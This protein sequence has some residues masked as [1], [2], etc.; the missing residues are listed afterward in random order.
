MRSIVVIFLLFVFAQYSTAQ[1]LLSGTYRNPK[2]EEFLIISD[3]SICF[4]LKTSEGLSSYCF[5][6]GTY[7][8]ADGLLSIIVDNTICYETSTILSNERADSLFSLRIVDV[9]DN[10]IKYGTVKIH[11]E[12][13]IDTKN[14]SSKIWKRW[15]K[16]RDKPG[17]GSI[18]DE[19]GFADDKVLMPFLNNVVCIEASTVGIEKMK[20]EFLIQ[21]GF[22]YVIKSRIPNG[23]FVCK[24][25]KM[26]IRVTI[27]PNGS[28]KYVTLFSEESGHEE[29]SVFLRISGNKEIGA[30]C[31]M[32]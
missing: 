27:M 28:L 24:S 13:N 25:K 19:N 31:F 26:E 12:N 17:T 3:D 23:V 18:T 8:Y 22:D 10:P 5:G 21:D 1:N 9:D 2:T 16:Y 14:C 7:N 29:S 15:T 11:Q 6:I 4:K 32:Y 20:Q 30:H